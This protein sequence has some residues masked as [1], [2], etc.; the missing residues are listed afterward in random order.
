MSGDGSDGGID[1]ARFDAEVL[2]AAFAA[3]P[4]GVTVVAARRAGEPVGMAAS[5]FTSVSLVPPLVSVC[6]ARTSATWPTLRAGERLGVSVLADDQDRLARQF[7]ARGRDRFADVRSTTPASG[8]V[9]ID[10]ACLW[11][12]CDVHAEF[13]AGDHVIALLEVHEIESFPQRRPLVFH[14]SEFRQL[15]FPP[16]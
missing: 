12:E 6:F 3:F 16:G 4:S 9:L 15:V 14:S 13:P 2:R 10:G 1:P 5:S 7:A 11:L 8:A